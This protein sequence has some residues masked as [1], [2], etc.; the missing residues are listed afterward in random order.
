MRLGEVMHSYPTLIAITL[1]IGLAGC[2]KLPQG[3]KGDAGP[4]GPPGPKGEAGPAGPAGPP[5]ASSAT[6]IVRSNCDATNCTA[7]CGDDEVLLIAYWGATRN[8]AIFPTERSASCRVRN[9]A[10]SPL[11]AACAKVAAASR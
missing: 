1:A 10:N 7:Q 8:A 9:P 6:R 11:V 3:E 4:A 2:G 5:G